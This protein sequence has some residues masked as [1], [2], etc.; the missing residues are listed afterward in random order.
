MGGGSCEA[1]E[2]SRC[3]SFLSLRRLGWH[4]RRHSGQ[5][6]HRIRRLSQ[7][8]LVARNS[9][10]PTIHEDCSEVA[11]RLVGDGGLYQAVSV[12]L[13]FNSLRF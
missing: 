6:I 8:H 5:T 10:E 4:S 11:C 2:Q 1:D 3:S 13:I 12:S 9:R 7:K